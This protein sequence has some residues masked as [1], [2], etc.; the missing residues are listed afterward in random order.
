MINNHDMWFTVSKKQ[1]ARCGKQT[2]KINLVD[3][4]CPKCRSLF[5]SLFYKK[6]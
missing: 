2:T 5:N 6:Y 3:G 4:L 1:C